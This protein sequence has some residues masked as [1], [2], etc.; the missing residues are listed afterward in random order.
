M[1]KIIAAITLIFLITLN[2][3][4]AQNDNKFMGFV[5]IQD[6]L[7]IPYKLEFAENNGVISGFSLTDYGGEH[8]TKSKIIG[9]YNAEDKTLQFKEVQLIYTKSPMDEYTFCN[10]HFEPSS[11]K[12]GSNKLSGFFKGRFNDG[13]ECVNGEIAMSS[14]EKIAKRVDKFSKKVK[15]SK[16]IADS[17]KE[18]VN[19]IKLVDTLNLNVLKKDEV[20]SI[21]SSSKSIKLS[22]YDGGQVD[23]DVISVKQNGKII[24]SKFKISE[25]RKVIEIPLLTQKIE[26]EFIS[27]SVGSIGSN[28]TIIEVVD[29]N[30]TIKAMTNIDKD[31]ITKIDIIKRK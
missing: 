17:L 23:G 10:V 31:E 27:N 21:L 14:I 22:I 1:K 3:T 8:E 16:R 5:K 11:F 6:T 19:K 12:L 2:H 28:T 24:L 30:S 20:T 18:K 13:I 29:G 4:Q 26:L 9:N 15:N 7:L 25:K